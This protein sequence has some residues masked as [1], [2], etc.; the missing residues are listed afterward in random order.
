MAAAECAPAMDRTP[1]D[2]DPAV[3]RGRE[4]D[5]MGGGSVAAYLRFRG[6]V[7]LTLVLSA[8]RCFFAWAGVLCTLSVVQPFGLLTSTVLPFTL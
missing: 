6:V 2:S 7:C 1:A 8:A 3:H 4:L 5:Y